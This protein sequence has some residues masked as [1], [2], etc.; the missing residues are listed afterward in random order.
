MKKGEGRERKKIEIAV[1]CVNKFF[2]QFRFL[3]LAKFLYGFFLTSRI[4]AQISQKFVLIIYN[5]ESMFIY[6]LD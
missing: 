6:D 1:V 2:V 3:F 4:L 5:D